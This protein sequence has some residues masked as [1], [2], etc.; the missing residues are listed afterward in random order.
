MSGHQERTPE[1]TSESTLLKRCQAGDKE[2]FGLVV[3]QYAGRATGAALLLL[4]RHEDALDASQE[5]FVRAWRHIRRFDPARPFY[6]WYATILRN[7]CLSRLRRLRRTRTQE[8]VPDHPGSG[9]S[10]PVLL[11]ERNERHDRVWKAILALKPRQREIIVLSHFQQMSY[12][13]IAA[14][15]DIPIGTVMSRLHA[16]RQALREKLAD[17]A[18]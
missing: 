9:D 18:P 15:V 7:V 13:E 17:D 10:N 6:P 5:A 12:K 3:R 14:A 16:A 8:L 2:A 4:G 1:P 11:A